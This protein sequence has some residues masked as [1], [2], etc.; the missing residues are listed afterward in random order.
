MTG[1]GERRGRWLVA[2]VVSLV[3]AVLGAVVLLVSPGADTS[4]VRAA[5]VATPSAQETTAPPLAVWRTATP[6][7]P[8][9]STPSAPSTAP[10][11]VATRTARPSAAVTITAPVIPTAPRAPRPD[12]T[13]TAPTPT[14]VPPPARPAD[15]V[16][17]S[18]NVLG[19]NHTT[20]GGTRPGWDPG[21]T[22]IHWAIQL[23]RRH[24]VD[25]VGLQEFQRPQWEIFLRAAGEY[26]VFP[27]PE[28]GIRD[29]DN[30]I[31][32]RTSEWT[33]IRARTIDIPYFNGKIKQ[34]PVV[35]LRH[36]ASGRPAWFANFH[37]PASLPWLPPQKRYR[38]EATRRQ[39]ALARG[40]M[41][42]HGYPVFVTGDMNDTDR[43]FCPFTRATGMIAADGGSVAGG[44]CQLPPRPRID[45]IF[46]SPDVRF[47]GYTVVDGPLARRTSDHAM[48]VARAVT[49]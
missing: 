35:L 32:W 28:S 41:R 39:S 47:S 10:S 6:T 4:Q 33:L 16:V 17:A 49:G 18:Y 38:D 31:A 9:P 12:V 29:T 34:M 25:V 44:R 11:S 24:R 1:P 48:I 5:A 27:G 26:A 42:D 7:S 21:S 20:P 22:R 45:W 30:S 13:R 14:R 2:A 37:N 15:F 40:L 8:A 46:G 36:R 23:L 3:T 43:Y 19:S